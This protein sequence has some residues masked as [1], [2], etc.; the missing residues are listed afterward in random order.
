MK[1]LKGH[2]DPGETDF[3]TALR[4]T[5]EEAGYLKEDLKIYE[6]AKQ[7]MQYL[8]NNKPKIVIY[9]LAELINK[10]KEVTMSSEHQDFKWLPLQPACDLAGYSEMKSALMYCDKYILE[11]CS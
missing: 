1:S 9:W 11:K 3:E 8:V 5:R 4:E 10:S 2:V 7:E 6:D